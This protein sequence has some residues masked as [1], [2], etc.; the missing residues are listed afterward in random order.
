MTGSIVLGC[1]SLLAKGPSKVGWKVLNVRAEL[2]KLT[3][4]YLGRSLGPAT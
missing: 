4:S 1:L 3:L 2:R